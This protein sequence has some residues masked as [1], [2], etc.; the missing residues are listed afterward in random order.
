MEMRLTKSVNVQP[1]NPCCASCG[2]DSLG[3]LRQQARDDGGIKGNDSSN[4]DYRILDAKRGARRGITRKRLTLLPLG[5]FN[6]WR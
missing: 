6:S 2:L 4:R 3:L 5:V 1:S